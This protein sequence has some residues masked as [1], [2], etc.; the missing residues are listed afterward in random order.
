MEMSHRD[1]G[2]PVQNA[3]TRATTLTRE[4]L[5]VPDDYHVLWMQGGA[6]AQFAATVM[7]CL[8]DRDQVDVV[9]TGYWSERFMTTDA[10]N[11][12]K[13]RKAWSGVDVNFRTIAPVSQWE[14]SPD[15][16]FVHMCANETI[17]GCEFLED[18]ELPTG[19]PPLSCDATSTL[20]S[21]PMDISKYGIVYASGGKNIGP[22][23]SCVVIVHNELLGKAMQTCPSVLDYTKQATTQPIP[24]LYNTPPTYNLYMN[25][26]VLEEYAKMGGLSELCRRNETRAQMVYDVIDAS[27]GFY[28]NGVDPRVRSRMNMPFRIAYGRD[29]T[30][31]E[32]FCAEAAESGIEQLFCHPLFPGLRVT[33]YNGLPD[34]TT[35]RLTEFMHN[36][37]ERHKARGEDLIGDGPASVAVAAGSATA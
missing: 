22:A 12:T 24:S 35:S 32:A 1:A 27:G 29:P 17:Q 20:M 5:E 28:Y 26:L 16:A 7:N 6:H 2:G 11:L 23:G 30:L 15:S 3:I 18:P 34:C 8:G 14:V 33:L 37:S 4:L 36:F 9:H 10:P 25:S 31:E 13:V 19:S 21:R